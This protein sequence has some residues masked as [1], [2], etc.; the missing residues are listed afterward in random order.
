MNLKMS[1]K[2][3]AVVALGLIAFS[4]SE[5]DE[6]E[7]TFAPKNYNVNGKV[8]KGPFISGST[9]TIQPMNAKLQASGELYSSTIQDNAG[10]FSFGSKMF[11][12]PYAELTANGY[13][14]NEVI[15]NLS[16]GTL[17]LRGLVD[18]SD[19]TTVNVNILT[20]LKYQRVTAL[21]EKGESFTNANK[22]AQK[23]LFTAFGLQKYADTDASRFSIIGGNEE[24]GALI[25]ISSLLIVDRSEAELTEYL[26]KLCREFGQ[27]GTFT[28]ATK[29]QIKSDREELSKHLSS[30]KSNIISRY[31]D[32]G[33]SVEVK[34]LAFFLDWDDDG[35]A[36]NETLKEGQTV[37]LETTQLDVPN[38]GGV[39]NIKITSPIPV[40]LKPVVGLW[41]E[42]SS[43]IT[44]ETL[45]TTLYD[46]I[47]DSG[48]SLEKSLEGDV[49]T[50]KVS[51]LNSRFAKST[52]IYV[53]DCIG[54]IL[55]TVSVSQEGNKDTSIPLLGT[56]G[57][58]A[59]AGM[60]VSI[61]KAFSELNLLEQHYHY[62]K[63]AN[64]VV[65]YINPNRSY[66]SWTNFYTANR[67]NLTI[68]D[69]DAQRLNMYQD[70]FNVFS[71]LSYYHMV[72][73]WGGVPYIT[74]YSWY[75]NMNFSIARTDETVILNDLK[76]TLKSAIAGQYL[77]EK[78]NESLKDINGYFFVSKD[79]ARILLADIYMYQGDYVNAEALLQKVITNGYYELDASNYSKE[80][81]INNLRNNKGGKETIFATL[82]DNGTRTRSTITIKYPDLIPLMTY[83]DVI[84]SYAECL[85][86]NGKPDAR[87]YLNKV[88]SAKGITVSNDVFAG[89]KE[90][91]KQL[92]LYSVGNFAFMKRNG[93]AKD[94]YG[95][96]TY[97]LLLPIPSAE[98]NN[99]PLMTQNPGY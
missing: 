1:F 74:D 23:E 68:K 12:A 37:T 4:C 84:L 98:V 89:I 93:I 44:E 70:I 31:E 86:K 26:A 15:G 47:S 43:S 72:V 45:F 95:V 48:I 80:E 73:F 50:I 85:Y 39:Y 57:Q 46:E 40:Y 41:D 62:N 18:L 77:E 91:R 52:S 3:I 32:L 20:H 79:V 27:S 88:V 25:A 87:N 63:D 58:G 9:I 30:I 13:F 54:N 75:A 29:S 60:A 92:M 71:A 67:M 22:Q 33:L 82:Y 76:A 11:D 49:L 36:G 35:E 94:E 38:N 5:S 34:E 21:V 28:E 61:A 81:T 59:V 83:T 96:E 16:Q 17:S 78:K 56:S 65:Q 8:E 2:A 99:N 42:P 14:F 90:A 24:A 97:R 66:D 53:Y 6:S 69:A 55:G 19:A 64:T 51:P 7:E 10:N